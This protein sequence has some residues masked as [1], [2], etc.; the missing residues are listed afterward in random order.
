MRVSERTL[1][2]PD[3]ESSKDVFLLLKN[4]LYWHFCESFLTFCQ[5]CHQFP[6]DKE[7]LSG[8]LKAKSIKQSL[9]TK[10][11]ASLKTKQNTEMIIKNKTSRKASCGEIASSSTAELCQKGPTWIKLEC[12]SGYTLKA[13]WVIEWC[14]CRIE[15]T[16]IHN[17]TRSFNACLFSMYYVSASANNLLELLLLFYKILVVIFFMYFQGFLGGS[18]VKNSPPSA[19]DMG[20]IPGPGGFPMPWSNWALAPQLLSLCSRAWDLQL[21]TLRVLEP[22]LCNQRSPCNE[23]PVHSN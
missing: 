22:K 4:I 17:H 1:I 10:L 15:Q 21:L 19:G 2:N 18:M 23:R 9:I 16:L 8:F 5:F 14:V 13:F 20:L 6:R 12:S 7:I 3:R 11:P